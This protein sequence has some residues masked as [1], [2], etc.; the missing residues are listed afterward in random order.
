MIKRECLPGTLIIYGEWDDCTDRQF[1][2]DWREAGENCTVILLS[3]FDYGG[4]VTKWF[5]ASHLEVERIVTNTSDD[6]YEM[7]EKL[8]KLEK[9]M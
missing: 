1:I 2:V 3:G 5:E 9:V 7:K 6:G 8:A 4:G